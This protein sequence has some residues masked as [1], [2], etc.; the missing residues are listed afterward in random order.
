MPLGKITEVLDREELV[1]LRE[2]E[3]LRISLEELFLL[4]Q[5]EC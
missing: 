2:Y 3:K 5:F 4:L 1:Y